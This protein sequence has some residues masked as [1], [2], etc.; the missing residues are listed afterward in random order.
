MATYLMKD[1]DKKWGAE[2]VEDTSQS[3]MKIRFVY[4]VKGT[5]TALSFVEEANI[6][7]F[8]L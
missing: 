4:V 7:R 2:V 5:M 3:I 8:S 6:K 1:H